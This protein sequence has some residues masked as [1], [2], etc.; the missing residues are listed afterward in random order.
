MSVRYTDIE[1]IKADLF[2][3]IEAVIDILKNELS[4]NKEIMSAI[5]KYEESVIANRNAIKIDLKNMIEF[6]NKA[7][8]K[9]FISGKDLR[10]FYEIREEIR[11][12][13]EFLKNLK[14]F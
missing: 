9:A 7:L 14:T 1:K 4:D 10:A 3:N 5:S 11:K 8:T 2:E 6:Y 12:S 13:L